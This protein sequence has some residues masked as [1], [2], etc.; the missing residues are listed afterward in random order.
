MQQR[1][2]TIVS[3]SSK[4]TCYLRIIREDNG[5]QH[6]YRVGPSAVNLGGSS[7]VW[8]YNPNISLLV[9]YNGSSQNDAD[10]IFVFMNVPSDFLNVFCIKTY[11]GE[12]S[13][14]SD[15]YVE[16]EAIIWTIGEGCV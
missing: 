9:F 12:G 1:D 2:A 16:R 7:G 14:M 5:N 3:K 8:R 10:V 11:T 4:A 13:I 15:G 6:W